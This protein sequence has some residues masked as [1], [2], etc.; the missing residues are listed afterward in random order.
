MAVSGFDGAA[1]AAGALFSFV[2]DIRLLLATGTSLLGLVW[3]R[4]GLT[5]DGFLA[6]ASVGNAMASVDRGNG[7]HLISSAASSD[8]VLITA[9]DGS[10]DVCK[11]SASLLK[12]IATVLACSHSSA[13]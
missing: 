13:T 3:E 11:S 8:V 9:N 2:A 1:A 6:L 4:D 5:S 7:G 12:C 10:G